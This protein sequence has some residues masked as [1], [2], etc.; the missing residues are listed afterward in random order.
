MKES[1]CWVHWDDGGITREHFKQNGTEGLQELS[2]EEARRIDPEMFAE[3]IDRPYG[4]CPTLKALYEGK[5][6]E[7]Q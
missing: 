7:V 4:D 3:C 1:D 2:E 6:K 5:C